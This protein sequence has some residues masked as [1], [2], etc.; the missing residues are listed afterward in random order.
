VMVDDCARSDGEPWCMAEK[1]EAEW[2]WHLANPRE[3]RVSEWR[4]QNVLAAGGG[5]RGGGGGGDV[6]R[7]LRQIEAILASDIARYRSLMLDGFGMT[8]QQRYLE[9]Q[10]ISLGKRDEEDDD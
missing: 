2:R 9:L 10:Q 8:Y 6:Q 7:E 3:R 5:S 1:S 4:R